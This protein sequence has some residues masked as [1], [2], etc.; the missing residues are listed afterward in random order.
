M[1]ETVAAAA[2]ETQRYPKRGLVAHS[3]HAT[4]PFGIGEGGLVIT[5]DPDLADRAHQMTNFGT[6][7]RITQMSGEN[8]KMSEYHAAV[9]LAQLNRWEGI[10]ARRAAVYAKFKEELKPACGIA[11]LPLVFDTAIVSSLMLRV[12]EVDAA[13]LAGKL[14]AKGLPIHR[15]YLPPLYMH[16]HFAGAE[17]ANAQGTLI[18]AQD[19]RLRQAHMPGSQELHETLIGLPFH[20]M[21]EPQEIH[22]IVALFVQTLWKETGY[23]NE[24]YPSCCS[25]LT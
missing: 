18:T 16:P 19:E 9:A 15:T 17:I 10:K 25:S 2:I 7:G 4:K 8:A 23:E 14:L 12:K 21:M 11:H 13:L 5:Y 6:M 3:L 24:G 20:P 22:D 1:T